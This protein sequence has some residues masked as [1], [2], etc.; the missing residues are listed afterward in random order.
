MSVSNE[1]I[2]A[3]LR[4]ADA[5]K[6]QDGASESVR[7]FW[8]GYAKGLRDLQSGAAKKAAAKD[9][10][11]QQTASGPVLGNGGDEAA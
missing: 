3:L 9:S 5:L 4:R 8:R 1:E 10:V 11:A 2:G 6:D 7:A